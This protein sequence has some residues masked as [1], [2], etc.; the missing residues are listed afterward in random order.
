MQQIDST[1]LG[2]ALVILGLIIVYDVWTLIDRGY[3]TTISWSIYAL[4]VRFPIIPFALGVV[5]GHLF[6]T[7]KAGG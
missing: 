4:S 7:N 3:N 2:F 5:C 1:T 6:W